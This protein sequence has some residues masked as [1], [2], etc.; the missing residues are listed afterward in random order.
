MGTNRNTLNNKQAWG[1]E[2]HANKFYQPSVSLPQAFLSL[3]DLLYFA[4]STAFLT[5]SSMG[6]PQ[7]TSSPSPA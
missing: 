1:K 7:Q 3:P 5:V 2:S 4:A 6:S